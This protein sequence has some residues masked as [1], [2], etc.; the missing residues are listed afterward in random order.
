MSMYKQFSTSPDK[1]AKGAVIEYPDFRVTVARAGGANKKYTQTLEA[2][3][4]PYRRA[5]QNGV[6]DNDLADDILLRVFAQTV[7]LNW[8]VLDDP[9]KRTW[10]V[11]IESP[12]GGKP[13]PFNEENVVATLRALPDLFLD[14]QQQAQ[15]VANFREG[16]LEEDSKNS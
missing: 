8:E 11:G 5:I 10:K 2:M 15:N 16:E 4:R 3:A 13:L 12:D 9:K 1:E 7:V 6:M 14:L